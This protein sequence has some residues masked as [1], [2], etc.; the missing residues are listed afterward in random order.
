MGSEMWARAT[1]AAFDK[2]GREECREVAKPEWWNDAGLK[3]L[4]AR[5]V[6]AAPNNQ[7]ATQMRAAVLCG[8]TFGAWE[9]GP[10]SAAELKEAVTCFE[11][12]AAIHPAPAARAKLLSLADW[13]RSQAGAVY[14][15]AAPSVCTGF[16]RGGDGR[17]SRRRDA[18]PRR[19]SKVDTRLARTRCGSNV[20]NVRITESEIRRG[21]WQ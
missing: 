12:T 7:A 10:R 20:V 16:M 1:A 19:G 6:R 9:A 13:C 8:V 15:S 4:S 21:G 11:R 14:E 3:A 2:L 17:S 18:R 5:V